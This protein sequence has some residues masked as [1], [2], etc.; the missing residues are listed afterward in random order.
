MLIY[1][2]YQCLIKQDMDVKLSLARVLCEQ[3][4]EDGIVFPINVS[5]N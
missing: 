5:Q 3:H 1:N 4:N 2:G